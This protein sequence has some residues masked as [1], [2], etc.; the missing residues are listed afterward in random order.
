MNTPPLSRYARVAAL[1]VVSLVGGAVRAETRP[2]ELEVGLSQGAV[3]SRWGAPLEKEE[4]ETKRHEVWRYRGGSQVAFAEGK[5][6][7]WVLG[8]GV[9]D[10][11]AL[12]VPGTGASGGGKTAAS[13]EEVVMSDGDVK[14]LLD[15]MVER[16][17][18]TA[19]K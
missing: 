19:G 4:R 17:G 12:P 9:F 8:M 18:D 5:V 15:E 7:T 16:T 1:L 3:L 14:A 11:R 10:S 13:P 6:V 2:A